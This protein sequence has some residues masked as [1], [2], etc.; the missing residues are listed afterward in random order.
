MTKISC[1]NSFLNKSIKDNKPTISLIFLTWLPDVS[2]VASQSVHHQNYIKFFPCEGASDLEKCTEVRFASF[3]SGGF[4]TA[5]VIVT[6]II[7][8]KGSWQNVS[9]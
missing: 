4:I 6:A 9:L 1:P 7:H 3:L 8:R 5:V 2:L